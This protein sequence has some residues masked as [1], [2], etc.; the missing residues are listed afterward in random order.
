[1][2]PPCSPLQ[3]TV[4]RTNYRL[5]NDKGRSI[6]TTHSFT[7][8]PAEHKDSAKFPCSEPVLVRSKANRLNETLDAAS[9]TVIRYLES[10]QRLRV[11]HADIDFIVDADAQLWLYVARVDAEPLASAS[12]RTNSCCPLKRC[13]SAFLHEPSFCALSSCLPHTRMHTRTQS[14][15]LSPSLSRCLS[16][17]LSSHA[18][19]LSANKV[20]L[21][22]MVHGQ[23]QGLNPS[24]ASHLVQGMDRRRLRG[25]RRGECRGGAGQRW[26]QGLVVAGGDEATNADGRP[27]TI[28]PAPPQASG[29]ENGR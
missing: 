24:S 6:T 17:A 18:I 9:R 15:S 12:S 23:A 22:S 29:E 13:E 25:T 11:V 28:A 7:T 10:S 8:V 1:M 2:S 16:V 3:G 5:V 21:L 20:A 4:Y 27:A 19:A 14:L 26:G